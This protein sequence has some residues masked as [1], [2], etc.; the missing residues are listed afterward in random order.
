MRSSEGRDSRL[1]S[2]IRAATL[3][4]SGDA[5]LCYAARHEDRETSDAMS[6]SISQRRRPRAD[7]IAERLLRFI[8]KI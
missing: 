3:L 8:A 7:T 2:L 5:L 6:F 4:M 1:I